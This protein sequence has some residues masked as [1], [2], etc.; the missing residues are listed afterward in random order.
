MRWRITKKPKPE[1]KRWFAWH[2]I[3]TLDGTYVWLEYVET[4]KEFWS[5]GG[6]CGISTYYRDGEKS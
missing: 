6:C 1:W 2:P 4:K 5:C 3:K